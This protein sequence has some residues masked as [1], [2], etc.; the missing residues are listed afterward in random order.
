MHTNFSD[1]FCNS[2]GKLKQFRL[3]QKKYDKM[4]KE[5]SWNEAKKDPALHKAMMCQ[6]RLKVQKSRMKGI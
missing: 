4:Y 6:Q 5:K 1:K 3:N 2:I